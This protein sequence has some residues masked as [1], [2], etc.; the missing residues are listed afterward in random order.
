MT[1]A[2]NPFGVSEEQEFEAQM[3][4]SRFEEARRHTYGGDHA[5]KNKESAASPES[6]AK[7]NMYSQLQEEI[8]DDWRRK[9]ALD[10]KG[11][12]F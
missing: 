1:S 5:R 6:G 12:S 9:S 7:I 11:S 4:A 8:K 3:M 10:P 2:E